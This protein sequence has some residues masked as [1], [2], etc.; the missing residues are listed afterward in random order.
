MPGMQS[1]WN[2]IT[3][4][5]LQGPILGPYLFLLFINDIAHDI[6]SSR[7]LFADG[8]SLYSIVEDWNSA[9]ELLN[10][11]IEKIAE[12]AQTWLVKSNTS[13]LNLC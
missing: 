12:M 7:Q 10:S 5:I 9:A 6:G 13:K 1:V 2:F 11:D 3:A 8:T 4:G